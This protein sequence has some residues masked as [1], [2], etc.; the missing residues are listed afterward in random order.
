MDGRLGEDLGGTEIEMPDGVV[1]LGEVLA[2]IGAGSRMGLHQRSVVEDEVG[3]PDAE[4]TGTG[5]ARMITGGYHH[6][7]GIVILRL[8]GA[9]DAEPGTV[10][11]AGEGR[12]TRDLVVH[13]AGTL[14]MIKCA[15]DT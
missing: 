11:Q 3:V 1:L 5:I 10:G 2:A 9:V 12:E 8:F 6:L 14:D 15:A 13:H 4:K 7:E